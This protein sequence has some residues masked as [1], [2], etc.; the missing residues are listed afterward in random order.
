[1][2]GLPIPLLEHLVRIAKLSAGYSSVEQNHY[3]NYACELIS[4]FF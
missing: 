1:M 3:E 2:R 4:I